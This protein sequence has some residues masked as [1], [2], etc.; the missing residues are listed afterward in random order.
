M[1]VMYGSNVS[2]KVVFT[3]SVIAVQLRVHAV[4]VYRVYDKANEMIRTYSGRVT[5]F[6]EIL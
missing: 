3:C 1:Y 2:V 5:Y 6:L 4:N